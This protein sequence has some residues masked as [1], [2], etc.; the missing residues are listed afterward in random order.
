[1][2]AS[3]AWERTWGRLLRQ[4]P[5]TGLLS[6]AAGL[7]P[8]GPSES[9]RASRSATLVAEARAN[10]GAPVRA[11]L[12]TQEVYSFTAIAAVAIAERVLAGDFQI[13]FQ[14]PARVYGAD[15][16]L[17]LPGVSREDL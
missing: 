16:V 8:D 9:R 17:S 3:L 15:F 10:G 11:R 4:G 2:R 5:W 7:L 12:K 6:R 1:M 13:G 14:T